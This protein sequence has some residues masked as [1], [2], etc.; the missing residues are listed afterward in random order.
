MFMP[1]KRIW[2]QSGV[3]DLVE[4]TVPKRAVHIY[5]DGLSQ[6]QVR[7][8]LNALATVVDTRGWAIKNLSPN[9]QA[10]EES[11]RLVGAQKRDELNERAEIVNNTMD[12]LDE[13][14]SRVAEQFTGLMEQSTKKHHDD[15]L[16]HMRSAGMSTP[17]PTT[18]VTGDQA[19]NQTVAQ[20][21]YQLPPA[22]PVTIGMGTPVQAAASTAVPTTTTEEAQ[23]LQHIHLKNEQEARSDQYGHLKTIQPINPYAPTSGIS[24]TPAQD[25]TQTNQTP[26]ITPVD[27]AILTLAH[28]DDLSI[29][30]IA[31]QAKKDKPDEPQEVVVS[32][33]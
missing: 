21:N 14:S 7:T 6:D 25:I 2:D 13:T 11:D 10:V 29:Q 32:L 3:K 28:N 17:A 23:L 1:R 27:P 8:R 5:S 33:H 16:E 31:H 4:I 22:A 20:T 15:V 26:S 30:A 24:M 19:D 18:V 9:N 12:V